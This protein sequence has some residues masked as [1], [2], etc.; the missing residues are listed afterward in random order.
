MKKQIVALLAGAMFMVGVANVANATPTLQ[1]DIAGGTYNTTTET[2]VACSNLFTLYAY[3]L[4]DGKSFLNDNYF[5]S[6]AL[7]PQQN[8]TTPSPS[9]GSFDYIA[10][11]TTTVH[12]TQDLMYFGTPPFESYQAFDSGDLSKHGIFPTYFKE[13]AFKFSANDQISEYNTQDRA[14]AGDP[15][16]ASGTG[17]YFKAFTFDLSHL[18]TGYGIHFDLYN[19]TVKNGDKDIRSFAPFS[20]DAEGMRHDNPPPAVPEPGTLMLL[21]MGMLGLAVYGKRRMNK[22]A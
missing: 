15:I 13:F 11:P 6:A 18:D 19:E 5:V 10:N 9:L 12:V 3:L 21:G 16:S 2:I 20:H 14:K 8:H 17:M 7:I 4:P 22:E 1:L